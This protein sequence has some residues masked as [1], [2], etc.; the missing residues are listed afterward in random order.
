MHH[1]RIMQG[2]SGVLLAGWG[3]CGGCKVLYHRCTVHQGSC[4]TEIQANICPYG[5]LEHSHMQKEVIFLNAV[6]QKS[7]YEQPRPS[8]E[9]NKNIHAYIQA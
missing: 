2:A 7:V 6:I 4:A 1:S 9:R 3:E 5:E 8:V